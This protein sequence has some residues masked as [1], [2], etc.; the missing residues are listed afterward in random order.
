MRITTYLACITLCCNATFAQAE[1]SAEELLNAID[2]MCDQ[3]VPERDTGS[4]LEFE[5][6]ASGGA[7]VRFFGLSVEGNLNSTEYDILNRQLK[8]LRRNLDDCRF[9]AF[10]LLKPVFIDGIS[11]DEFSKV[12]DKCQES[13]NLRVCIQTQNISFFG[14]NVRIP[15]TLAPIDEG[16]VNYIYS[17]DGFGRILTDTGGEYQQTKET[18]NQVRINAGETY[19]DL[20]SAKVDGFDQVGELAVEVCFK[21]PA[22]S[23]LFFDGIYPK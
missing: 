16:Y 17:G 3:G 7:A 15:V 20:F 1:T 19:T 9:E 14:S 12:T 8:G 5:G 22:N 23:C 21:Q 6:G 11:S 4:L 18:Y 13:G 2:R 10:R